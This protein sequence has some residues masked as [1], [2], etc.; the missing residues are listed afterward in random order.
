MMNIASIITG[1]NFLVDTLSAR[2][3]NILV[4]TSKCDFRPQESK[5]TVVLLP[6]HQIQKC[7]DLF[8]L[9]II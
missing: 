8:D 9:E 5:M 7:S 4:S 3:L 1:Q 6:N 2:T